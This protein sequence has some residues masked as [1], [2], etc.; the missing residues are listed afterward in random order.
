MMYEISDPDQILRTRSARASHANAGTG[1]LQFSERGVPLGVF[2]EA[3][4][5]NEAIQITAPMI[6]MS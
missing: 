2:N 4:R 6:L 3:K 5:D 1:Y